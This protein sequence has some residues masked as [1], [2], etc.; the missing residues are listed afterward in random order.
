MNLL[1]RLALFLSKY[2]KRIGICGNVGLI[3]GS[4]AGLILTLL[5]LVNG[6]LFLPQQEALFVAL[7]LTGFTWLVILFILYF[8]VRM[9]LQSTAIPSLV[10]C[11]LTCIATVFISSYLNAFSY[12]WLLGI[13]IGVLVGMSLCRLNSAFQRI[14]K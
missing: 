13:I 8:F 9:T 4:I 5:N 2:T 7:I 12:S 14:K 11:L 10:N 3:A 1:V 6:G